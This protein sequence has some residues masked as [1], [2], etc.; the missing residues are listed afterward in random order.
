MPTNR[1]TLQHHNH[2]Y[3]HNRNLH[4]GNIAGSSRSNRDT[5]TVHAHYGLFRVQWLQQQQL[6]CTEKPWETCRKMEE[7]HD[8]HYLP[9]ESVGGYFLQLRRLFSEEEE[10]GQGK[11]NDFEGMSTTRVAVRD[12]GGGRCGDGGGDG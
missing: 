11:K 2:N 7:R 6:V 4:Y 8:L 3:N 12:C 9:A 10:R 1:P 5:L